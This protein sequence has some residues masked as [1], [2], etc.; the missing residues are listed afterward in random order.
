MLLQALPV[1]PLKQDLRV[2]LLSLLQKMFSLSLSLS[3]KFSLLYLSSQKMYFTL[4]SLESDTNKKF[5]QLFCQFGGM[6]LLQLL[7]IVSHKMTT[8]TSKKNIFII[9]LKSKDIM[10]IKY[11]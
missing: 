9:I 7:P 4:L 8:T 1:C 5:L 2:G 6:N 3:P 10:L 11:L